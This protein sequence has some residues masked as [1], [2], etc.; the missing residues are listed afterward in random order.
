MWLEIWIIILLVLQAD[1]DKFY[2][3][4]PDA[5]NN[6]KPDAEDDGRI[7]GANNNGNIQVYN[8][9]NIGKE[10]IFEYNDPG[11][12]IEGDTDDYHDFD[13]FNQKYYLSS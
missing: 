5:N 11:F 10:I 13:S 12:G 3:Q 2:A 4:F 7:A 9:N 1:A 8:P 6:Q